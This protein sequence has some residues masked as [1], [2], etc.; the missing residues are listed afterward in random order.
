M[1]FLSSVKRRKW[2]ARRSSSGTVAGKV[3]TGEIQLPE[4][5]GAAFLPGDRVLVVADEGPTVLEEEGQ[6]VQSHGCQSYRDAERSLS[7]GSNSVIQ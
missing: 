5:S 6:L 1:A 2:P 4:I 7:Q 3:V